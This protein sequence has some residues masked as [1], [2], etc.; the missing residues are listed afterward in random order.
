METIRQNPIARA[1]DRRCTG[2]DLP[3]MT[4]FAGKDGESV[5][6]KDVQSPERCSTKFRCFCI[7]VG[8]L[9]ANKQQMLE[10]LRQSDEA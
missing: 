6:L 7:L 8:G 9:P 1:A 10:R 5:V 3:R 2:K 4:A